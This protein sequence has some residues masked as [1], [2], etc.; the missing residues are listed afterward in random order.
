MNSL[1]RAIAVPRSGT[2]PP[3]RFGWSASWV[4]AAL[5]CLCG[6]LF[7]YRA[8]LLSGFDLVFGDDGDARLAML[9]MEH[10]HLVLSGRAAFF[11][12]VFF[13]PAKDVIGFTDANFL[14]GLVFSLGRWMD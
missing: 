7:F 8:I 13:Y 11:S 10:W 5:C 9:L 14:Y 1:A 3:S 4:C 12:P 6:A 2:I